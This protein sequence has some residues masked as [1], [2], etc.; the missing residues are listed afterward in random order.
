MKFFR[1]FIV[2]FYHLIIGVLL[3]KLIVSAYNIV[4]VNRFAFSLGFIWSLIRSFAIPIIMYYFNRN[5]YRRLEHY[6]LSDVLS[7]LFHL[8]VNGVYFVFFIK[9]LVNFLTLLIY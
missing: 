8:I 4:F 7:L 9:T 2:L 6:E 3:F 1:T 5:Y